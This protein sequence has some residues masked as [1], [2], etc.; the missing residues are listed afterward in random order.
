MLPHKQDQTQ[1]QQELKQSILQMQLETLP[2]HQ[3]EQAQDQEQLHQLA[4]TLPQVQEL[5]Q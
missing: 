1:L 4:Q 2:L 3:L 5:A